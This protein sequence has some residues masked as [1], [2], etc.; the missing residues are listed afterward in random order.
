MKKINYR[1]YYFGYKIKIKYNNIKFLTH[2]FYFFKNKW[3]IVS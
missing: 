1:Q 3:N 2:Y